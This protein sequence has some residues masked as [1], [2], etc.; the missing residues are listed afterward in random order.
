[1]EAAVTNPSINADRLYAALEELGRIGAYTDEP[2]GLVGVRRLALSDEDRAA[3]ERVVAW[4]RELDLDVSVDAIG[5]VYAARAGR[6]DTLAPVM[7]GS[8]V[9][10]VPTGG[11]FDGALGVLGALEV[12]RTLA[13]Q[14]VTTRRPLVVGVFTDEEGCRFG[15]D[16]LGSAVATGRI[17]LEDACSL[18]DKNG[19]AVGD[20]LERIGFRGDEPVGARRPHAFVECH[21][22]QGPTLIR[23][24]YDV[25][26]VTKVQSISWQ[27][28]R[29]TG[30]AAHA[31][32]TP[33][34]YRIDA[35]LAASRINVR[36]REMVDGGDY[37][38][39]RA[40]M[41]V[42]RP[43]PDMINVIPGAMHVT[44]DLRNP[45]D[46][47]MEAAESALRAYVDELVERDGVGI[48]TRQTARTKVVPFAES[49]QS[50]IAA[51]ADG[52][53]LRHRRLFAG[54]GHDAQEWA[55]VCPTA[56]VF[57]P[58][59]HDG[60]SHNPRELSTPKQ[61]ADGIN[62]L[63]DTVLALAEQP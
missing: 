23:E 59:E 25:G 1:V 58:G 6:D 53:G 27:E 22:E 20:E 29:I 26:V 60:I 13:E 18:R 38:E 47:G 33:T 45:E 52:R 5:N 21:V 16:M 11:R 54:A 43:Q 9:D 41:G 14:G 48:E 36:L 17:T 30:R 55:A 50:V 28:M 44:V 62:V 40:T 39:L 12:V 32:A 3:R 46:T 7:F 34:A 24:G 56:M 63:L 8:H 61:C 19:L 10:S 15:T 35:G 37:G 49:V 57:V 42:M 2:T 51:A 31:G 4:M